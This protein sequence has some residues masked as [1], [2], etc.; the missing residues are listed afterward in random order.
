MSVQLRTVTTILS[1]PLIQEIAEIAAK[2]AL[3]KAQVIRLS[4]AQGL[5]T[6]RTLLG[7]DPNIAATEKRV[8]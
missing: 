1:E 8:A 4:L 7:L 3:H 6:T 2:T 5:P